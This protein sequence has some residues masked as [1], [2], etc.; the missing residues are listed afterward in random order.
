MLS[1]N[2]H[3]SRIFVESECIYFA[4]KILHY[5]QQNIESSTIFE[6]AECNMFFAKYIDRILLSIYM[7]IV[8]TNL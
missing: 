6:K 2:N 3:A 5:N 4:L 1:Q 8:L 7:L